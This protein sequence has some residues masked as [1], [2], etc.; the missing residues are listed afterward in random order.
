METTSDKPDRPRRRFHLPAAALTLAMLLAVGFG[1]V[2]LGGGSWK[3]VSAPGTPPLWSSGQFRLFAWVAGAA[4][5]ILAGAVG[6]LFRSRPWRARPD[7]QAGTAIIEFALVMPFILMLSL[8]MIQ[9]SMLMG[10]YLCVNY[11]SYCAARSAV[12]QIP[13][14][15]EGEYPS[16][17]RNALALLS[18]TGGAAEG[19]IESIHAAAVWAVVPVGDGS[20]SGSSPFGGRLAE[21][22][23]DLYAQYGRSGPGW[24]S[25]R[26]QA[27]CAYAEENT[28]VTV[29]PDSSPQGIGLTYV[30]PDEDIRV[31]VVHNL[32]LSIPYANVVLA[33]LDGDNAISLGDG[34]WAL[35]V[36]IPCMLRNEGIDDRVEIIGEQDE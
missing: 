17:P 3:A 25:T 4:G 26:L 29:E 14:D 28:T 31:R 30:G 20:Y 16:E 34:K 8:L 15:R 5:L 11:A 21:G 13:R 36:E 27:K 2:V 9:S 24:I 33:R 35:R 32:Y 22:V 10:G 6:V 23:Q 7:A 19:K 12:V 1:C 18:S